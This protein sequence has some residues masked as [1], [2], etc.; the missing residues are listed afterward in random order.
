MPDL[1]I[2]GAIY[3]AMSALKDIPATLVSI[4]PSSS[5]TGDPDEL[6]ATFRKQGNEESEIDVE[7]KLEDE[8][9]LDAASE[10]IEIL[11]MR[12]HD[13]LQMVQVFRCSLSFA[14]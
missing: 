3:E 8:E 9:P 7:I 14:L 13:I 6:A 4:T 5:E 1:I 2:W 11:K 10:R 12:F